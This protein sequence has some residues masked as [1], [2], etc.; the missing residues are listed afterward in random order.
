MKKI[1][2]CLMFF[3][4]A[5]FFPIFSFADNYNARIEENLKSKVIY[6][7]KI[8]EEK[9]TQNLIRMSIPI[10]ATKA[11]VDAAANR[12]ADSAV[13]K[14]RKELREATTKSLDTAATKNADAIK[15]AG[16]ATGLAVSGLGEKIDAKDSATAKE[17]S[18]QGGKIDS[19]IPAIKKAQNTMLWVIGAGLLLILLAVLALVPVSKRRFEH[20]GGKI[21]NVGEKIDENSVKTA[22]LIKTV[23]TL[24]P[25]TITLEN[26]CGHEV[27]YTP[28]IIEGEYEGLFV[29]ADAYKSQHP[30]ETIRFTHNRIGKLKG[31]V[32]SV[33][34]E[35]FKREQAKT[36]NDPDYFQQL[37]VI[38]YE[39]ARHRLD[40]KSV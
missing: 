21:D 6:R 20:I 34:A 8:I 1:I 19:I 38:R 32:R 16:V 31:S 13:N 30:E 37:E 5:S 9:N 14:I 3:L 17:I 29:P 23:T 15:A 40:W 22:K 11:E 18:A 25:I 7:G 35:Y 26:V 27:T 28:R 39:K 33:M 4:L 24:E 12:A 2:L 36:L 10:G